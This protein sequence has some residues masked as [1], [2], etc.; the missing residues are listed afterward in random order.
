MGGH[1]VGTSLG[2]MELFGLSDVDDL[3]MY[4]VI[5]SGQVEVLSAHGW[6][7]LGFG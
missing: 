2:F 7:V 4:G 1:F 6:G 3:E 5:F